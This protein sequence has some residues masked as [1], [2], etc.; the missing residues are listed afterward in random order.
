VYLPLSPVAGPDSGPATEPL[1]PA[2]HELP[3]ILDPDEETTAGQ[4]AWE[5]LAPMFWDLRRAVLLTT[6]W[7][8]GSSG[9]DGDDIV[10]DVVLQLY[11]A[12]RRGHIPREPRAWART[13]ARRYAWQAARRR[14]AELPMAADELIAMGGFVDETDKLAELAERDQ[15]LNW[16]RQL[17]PERRAVVA[18]YIDGY[19]SAEIAR[20]LQIPPKLVRI[21]LAAAR[22]ELR[23]AL[24]ARWTVTAALSRPNR[25]TDRPAAPSQHPGQGRP[26]TNS[27]LSARSPTCRP[28]KKK[29]CGSAGVATSLRRSH[30]SSGSAQT[31]Y[32]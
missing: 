5:L 15:L 3:K 9:A 16:V 25:A 6:A 13:V 24:L 32:A 31:Q 2:A 22:E 17:P 29:S 10:Q 14:T 8:P 1:T 26:L 21:R 30:V 28:G 27:P 12:L 7:M 20:Q 18:L 19:P 11:V 23:E 4:D